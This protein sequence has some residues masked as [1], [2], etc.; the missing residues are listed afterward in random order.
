M[1]PM[2]GGLKLCFQKQEIKKAHPPHPNNPRSHTP[3]TTSRNHRF[4]GS[5]SLLACQYKCNCAAGSANGT[6]T[7][8][9]CAFAAMRP[10][11]PAGIVSKASD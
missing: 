8:R 1:R 4:A 6:A 7:R 11:N 5:N 10:A 2:V 9:K 3:I